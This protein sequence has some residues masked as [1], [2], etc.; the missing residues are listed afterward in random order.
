MNR[1]LNFWS[2]IR[3]YNLI[4]TLRVTISLDLIEMVVV[5]YVLTFEADYTRCLDLEIQFSEMIALKIPKTLP[6]GSVIVLPK[7][8]EVFL[9]T[10]PGH[11]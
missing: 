8:V 7:L 9:Q 1:L 11:P 2:Y 4:Y 5:V 10:F 3:L 6:M